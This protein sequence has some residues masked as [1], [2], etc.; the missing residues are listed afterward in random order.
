[1]GLKPVEQQA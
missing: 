1:V